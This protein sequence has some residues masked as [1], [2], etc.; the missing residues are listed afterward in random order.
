MHHEGRV[1]G[2]GYG[3]WWHAFRSDFW[4]IVNGW[5]YVSRLILK[6][7]HQGVHRLRESFLDLLNR[8]CPARGQRDRKAKRV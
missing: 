6:R 8:L 3:G 5:I 4:D 1:A 7:A 2:R